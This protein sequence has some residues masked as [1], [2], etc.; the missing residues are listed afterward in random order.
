MA[1]PPPQPA[2][3]A[4]EPHFSSKDKV[5]RLRDGPG[6]SLA[7]NPMGTRGSGRLSG[8]APRSDRRAPRVLQGAGRA[9]GEVSFAAASAAPPAHLG[10]DADPGSSPGLAWL[11]GQLAGYIRQLG[12]APLLRAATSAA[13]TPAIWGSACHP[14]RPAQAPGQ[15]PRKRPKAGPA[16]HGGGPL[17]PGP[18]NGSCSGGEG[19]SQRPDS[20]SS[21]PTKVRPPGP[22][23]SRAAS[24]TMVADG[25]GF[26]SRVDPSKGESRRRWRRRRRKRTLTSTP[27]LL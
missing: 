17:R 21:G 3:P 7:S 1:C 5:T 10:L 22:G 16:R 2:P 6:P 11:S 14:T 15:R 26:S 25:D 20:R 19:R 23:P 4:P 24:L 18:H 9:K 27:A 12:R 8:R 13:A